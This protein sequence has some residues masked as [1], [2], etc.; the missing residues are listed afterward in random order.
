MHRLTIYYQ[1]RR[2]VAAVMAVLLITLPVPRAAAAESVAT[3]FAMDLP[4]PGSRVSSSPDYRPARL[5]GLT[6][7]PVHPLQLEFLIRPA[8]DGEA[9]AAFDAEAMTLVKY[10]LA[11]LTMPEDDMW[12]NLSPVEEDRIMPEEFGR[13]EMGRDLL[14][15]DYI[16]KQLTASLLYPEEEL[17]HDFWERVYQRAQQ[18]YGTTEIP[19]NTFNK[20]W[21]IPDRAVVQR[22]GQTVFVIDSRLKVM[23]EDDY[24]AMQGAA[25]A[26]AGP[27]EVTRTVMRDMILPEIEREVNSG[28]HFAKLR[29]IYDALILAVWYKQNLREGIIG[30]E[31]VDRA[32]TDG[33]DHAERAMRER[34]YTRYLEAFRKGV[35]NFV[36]E[37]YDPATREYMPRQYFSGGINHTA[38]ARTL[39]SS[40]Q[41]LTAEELAGHLEGVRVVRV[42]LRQLTAD[43]MPADS[44]LRNYPDAVPQAGFESHRPDMAIAAEFSPADYADIANRFVTGFVQYYQA[45]LRTT[46]NARELF[47]SDDTEGFMESDRLRQDLYHT[48]RGEIIEALKYLF[49]DNEREVLRPDFWEKLRAAFARQI[50]NTYESDIAHIFFDSVQR[51][52]WAEY[53][54]VME[55]SSFEFP[56]RTEKSETISRTYRLE[57]ERSLGELEN[58]GSLVRILNELIADL[59][60]DVS[61]PQL[62][63]DTRLAAAMILQQLRE[64]EIESPL[65]AVRILIPVFYTHDSANVVGKIELKDGTV[66]PVVIALRRQNGQTVIDAV[67]AGRQAAYD[68]L[69]SLTRSPYHVYTQ[70]YREIGAF[71]REVYPQAD[72]FQIYNLLGFHALYKALTIEQIERELAE[73]DNQLELINQTSD[74]ITFGI[75]GLPYVFEIIRRDAHDEGAVRNRFRRGHERDRMGQ[76]LDHWV[77]RNKAFAR[78]SVS[79]ELFALLREKAGDGSR[80][81]GDQVFFERLYVRKRIT[82]VTQYLQKIPPDQQRN[83]YLRVGRTIKNLAA[84]G[85]FPMNFGLEHFAVTSW[86]QVVYTNTA[87]IGGIEARRFARLADKEAED[88]RIA[89]SGDV[90]HLTVYPETFEDQL[91]IPEP[92]REVFNALHGDLFTVAFWDTAKGG[93]QQHNVA[94]LYPYTRQYRL[95][96]WQLRDAIRAGISG[97][98]RAMSIQSIFGSRQVSR[99]VNGIMRAIVEG[100]RVD[101]ID[102][103]NDNDE[104]LEISFAIRDDVLRIYMFY[105]KDMGSTQD[106]YHLNRGRAWLRTVDIPIQEYREVIIPKSDKNTFGRNALFMLLVGEHGIKDLTGNKGA[107]FND[108]QALGMKYPPG[109][110]LSVDFVDTLTEEN[111]ADH[112]SEIYQELNKYMWYFIGEDGRDEH[113][114]FKFSVRSSPVTSRPGILTTVLDRGS[115]QEIRDAIIELLRVRRN[116]TRKEGKGAI[117]MAIIIQEMRY[118]TAA[119]VDTVNP[120]TGEPGFFGRIIENQTGDELMTGG[121]QGRDFNVLKDERPDV[122]AQI[123]RDLNRLVAERKGHYP[124]QV[125]LVIQDDG[126]VFYL[127]TRDT[128]M[129]PQAEISFLRRQMAAGLMSEANILPRIDELQRRLAGRQVY[130]VK[131]GINRDILFRGGASTAGAMQGELTADPQRA[132]ALIGQG[133]PVILVL[134]EDNR[135]AMLDLTFSEEAKQAGVGVITDYG[136]ESDHEA[137]TTRAAGIPSII[138]IQ[139][140][141]VRREGILIEHDDGG[142]TLLRFGEE[143]VID[144]NGNAVFHSGGRKGLLV[145]DK[146]VEDASYGIDSTAYRR[147]ISAPYLTPFG[148]A[149]LDEHKDPKKFKVTKG[150]IRA[151]FTYADLL[152][153][154]IDAGRAYRRAAQSGNARAAFT[155]NLQQHFIHDLVEVAARAEGVESWEFNADIE[156]LDLIAMLDESKDPRSDWREY[157]RILR[158]LGEKNDLRAVAPIYAKWLH[159]TPGVQRV[160]REVLTGFTHPR[161]LQELY[162]L[163]AEQPQADGFIEA[164]ERQLQ[165]YLEP[166][167]QRI[168]RKSILDLS[169]SERLAK[170]LLTEAGL[171][172]GGVSRLPEYLSERQGRIF[173]HFVDFSERGLE[174]RY[175]DEASI[176]VRLIDDAEYLVDN[177]QLAAVSADN[178]GGI[179]FDPG[180]LN[181]SV[182]GRAV[183][184]EDVFRPSVAE[185]EPL[186]PGFSGFAPILINISPVNIPLLLGEDTVAP[187]ISPQLSAARAF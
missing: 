4:E 29:Q 38:I 170:M 162:R 84:M 179:D 82:P 167:L 168:A 120:D 26:Q 114:Q 107:S 143:V 166:F 176:F 161:T 134:T 99:A 97:T 58:D 77:Y 73:T 65:R 186:V 17:G 184:G 165:R 18:R 119:V 125:E 175:G 98:G 104:T 3:G 30:Q 72:H 183:S 101:L 90:G 36:K 32:K 152:T 96:V 34:I 148:L 5:T 6:V 122:Y 151:E 100:E 127:S 121:A 140:A 69:L 109:M 171:I 49:R 172:S 155:A 46:A 41:A 47:E 180:L 10:F 131:A 55:P 102:M 159:G 59:D 123:T 163:R 142:T 113:T 62:E 116:V 61:Y 111:V 56:V 147:E 52:V 79:D 169:E 153:I 150:V 88:A 15:Q 11:S 86:G 133:R 112:M 110:L 92:F 50:G 154:R 7:D 105:D 39:Q 130:K 19:V 51:I 173:E 70:H 136:N 87:G 141:V 16:L 78:D 68:F 185:Q 138:N 158:V 43:V 149:M 37:E 85:I 66:I 67:M 76:L 20:V 160:A 144:A 13:T 27:D 14:A 137:V 31:Y 8:E 42:G 91:N 139:N 115:S 23:L 157:Q 21:I 24:L 94:D 74:V 2:R 54:A 22:Q 118:G 129:F 128:K 108:F 178:P 83:V 174:F 12:V 57:Q 93:I 126:T 146:T 132:G 156:V 1:V 106:L 28:R 80:V 89:V 63:E 40:D 71:T 135:N 177:A 75:N 187:A 44:I 145:K 45:F 35:Y 182:L 164:F 81:E 33:V 48:A 181:L 25:P 53:G 95:K 117:P 124:Q 103:W 9:T 64:E 60:L